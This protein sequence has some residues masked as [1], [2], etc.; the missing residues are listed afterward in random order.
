VVLPQVSSSQVRALL[1]S[2]GDATRLVPRA[3][4]EA[5]AAAGSYR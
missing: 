3:V 1:A 2:G 5:I 4:L